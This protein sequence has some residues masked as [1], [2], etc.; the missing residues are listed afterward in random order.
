MAILISSSKQTPLPRIDEHQT[1]GRWAKEEASHHINYLELL[2]ILLAN[3]PFCAT[4][5]NCH[6][7]VQCHNTTA[8]CYVNNMG[9]SQSK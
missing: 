2:A 9:G 1:G 5:S 6:I 3:K 4:C 8:V 7:Q